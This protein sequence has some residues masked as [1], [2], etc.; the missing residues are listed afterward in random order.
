[1]FGPKR[2][3]I[4]GRGTVPDVPVQPTRADVLAGRDA[5]LEAALRLLR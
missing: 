3:L 1:V 4:E 5:D 2:G